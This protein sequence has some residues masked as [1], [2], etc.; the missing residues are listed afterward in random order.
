[1]MVVMVMMM[2]II[3]CMLDLHRNVVSEPLWAWYSKRAAQTLLT[4]FF[5]I[6]SQTDV[7]L[8]HNISCCKT[9]EDQI[10]STI[11]G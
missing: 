11:I 5:V 9:L 8:K 10:V 6:M 1:M 4:C 7:H 3:F 2:M